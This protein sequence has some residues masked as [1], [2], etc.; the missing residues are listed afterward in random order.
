MLWTQLRAALRPSSARQLRMP[1]R[2]WVG[3]LAGGPV[4]VDCGLLVDWGAPVP[5]DWGAPVPVDCL[6]W[7]FRVKE[8][9]ARVAAAPS[10][11]YAHRRT[12]PGA[13]GV[14][15]TGMEKLPAASGTSSWVRTTIEPLLLANCAPSQRSGGHVDVTVVGIAS[16]LNQYENA[17]SPGGGGGIVPVAWRSIG[18]PTTGVADAVSLSVKPTSGSALAAPSTAVRATA[19]ST[20]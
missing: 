6:G 17:R 4:P 7:M 8:A 14:T 20:L 13:D 10:S 16:R 15:A 2:T 18:G 9:A 1:R 19:A 11:V 12:E 3:M 5:V